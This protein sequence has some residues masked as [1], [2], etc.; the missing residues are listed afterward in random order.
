MSAMKKIFL[1][2]SILALTMCSCV[3]AESSDDTAQLAFKA[4]SGNADALTDGDI[5]T[6]WEPKGADAKL[7]IKL[8]EGAGYICIDWLKVPSDFTFQQFDAEQDQI[9][10]TSLEDLYSGLR[11]TIPLSPDA[12]FAVLSMNK[13]GQKVSEI[14]VY[15]VD[16]MPADAQDWSAPLSKVDVLVIAARPGDEFNCFGGLIP[17]NIALGRSVQVVYMTG[18]DRME[19]HKALSALWSAGITAYPEFLGQSAENPDTVKKAVSQWGGKEKLVGA[20]TS[21][22]RRY[23]PE[24][25][26]THSE[27][28]ENNDAFR[29]ATAQAL[30]LAVEASWDETQYKKSAEKYGAWQVKKLYTHTGTEDIVILDWTQPAEAL[31]GRTP[32]EAARAAYELYE[33]SVDKPYQGDDNTFHLAYT[34]IGPDIAHNDVYENVQM[35]VKPT[36]TPKPYYD[37]ADV[38]PEAT[39][40]IAFSPEPTPQPTPEPGSADGFGNATRKTALL[41]CGGIGVMLIVSG[42]QVLIYILRRRRRHWYD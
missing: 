25:I 30:L 24:V 35:E 27:N 37:S 9:S 36:A 40:A 32:N 38:A 14:T 1:M 18:T 34:H 2:V 33:V 39:P 5:L 11:H 41:V 28:G 13:K 26:V 20:M 31:D 16:S 29:A 3:M 23:Q 19:Q 15:P 6:A 7:K 10:S 21:L 12:R 4:S 17:Q 8:P 22:I 42:I